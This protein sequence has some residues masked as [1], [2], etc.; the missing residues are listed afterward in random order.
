VT[1]SDAP[2]RTELGEFAPN[3]ATGWDGLSRTLA[4]R[5]PADLQHAA[6]M[7]TAASRRLARLR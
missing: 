4:R 7:R 1:A 3:A 2:P 5:L 6:T